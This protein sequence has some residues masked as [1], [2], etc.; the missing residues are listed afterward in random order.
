V[1]NDFEYSLHNVIRISK[2][3]EGAYCKP[4]RDGILNLNTETNKYTMLLYLNTPTGG[5]TVFHNKEF[6]TFREAFSGYNDITITPKTG[7]I[8]VFDPTIAHE[9]VECKNVKYSLRTDIMIPS[10]RY[11]QKNDSWMVD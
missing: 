10:R 1:F 11:I 8:I 5:E 7:T 3:L 4:H 9:S 2:Y 6:N